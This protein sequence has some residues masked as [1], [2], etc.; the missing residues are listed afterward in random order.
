[1]T[2]EIMSYKYPPIYKYGFLLL[3][4]FMFFKHQKIMS[5]EKILINTVAL[6]LFFG[7]VDYIMIENHPNLFYSKNQDVDIKTRE[8]FSEDI[9]EI[10]DA[11]DVSILNN[12]EEDNRNTNHNVNIDIQRQYSQQIGQP[13]QYYSTEQIYY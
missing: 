9:E 1:M 8:D 3:I 7:V 10:L 12:I 4:I 2:N 5:Q 13:R 11:D 6:T